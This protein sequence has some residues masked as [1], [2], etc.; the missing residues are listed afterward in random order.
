[1]MAI[2]TFCTPL[3]SNIPS[4]ESQL[5]QNWRQLNPLPVQIPE[6]MA[7][8]LTAIPTFGETCPLAELGSKAKDIHRN[9]IHI[10]FL[11]SST[12]EVSIPYQQ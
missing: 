3:K 4:I 1:M 10:R 6:T 11:N 9:Q 12:P 7:F 5:Y 8:D 2:S